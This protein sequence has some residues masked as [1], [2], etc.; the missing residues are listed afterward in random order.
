MP[1]EHFD[2]PIVIRSPI[3]VKTDPT[4]CLRDFRKNRNPIEARTKLQTKNKSKSIIAISNHHIT[5]H[6]LTTKPTHSYQ[7]IV[8]STLQTL[9]SDAYEGFLAINFPATPLPSCSKAMPN[10]ALTYCS[11]ATV[12]LPL[13]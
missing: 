4:F 3:Q 9:S 13:D 6:Q 1:Y 12:T 11:L 8:K 2:L 7:P 10:N 5:C